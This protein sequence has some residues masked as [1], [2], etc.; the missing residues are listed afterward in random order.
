MDG[1]ENVPVTQTVRY[2]HKGGKENNKRPPT[3]LETL[4]VC[5]RRDFAQEVA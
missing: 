4:K 1:G 5:L 3:R 2:L